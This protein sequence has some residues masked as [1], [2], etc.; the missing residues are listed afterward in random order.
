MSGSIRSRMIA[1]G[2][3]LRAS[4]IPSR[5]L[6]AAMTRKP[7]NSRASGRPR[8]M[9]GSSATPGMVRWAAAIARSA[10]AA[11]APATAAALEH[12]DAGLDALQV[13]GRAVRDGAGREDDRLRALARR[14]ARDVAPA[15]VGAALA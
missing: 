11:S 7:S 14:G 10:A 1:S 9:W 4:A 6:L 12:A 2:A 13:R 3:S 5:A 15:L 8:T